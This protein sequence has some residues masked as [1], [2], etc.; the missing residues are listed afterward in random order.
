M[1]NQVRVILTRWH[2]TTN[3]KFSIEALYREQIDQHHPITKNLILSLREFSGLHATV[4]Y[5][6]DDSRNKEFE[7]SLYIASIPLP[8]L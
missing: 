7:K 8:R 5:Y 4:W 2:Y 6:R 3:P 1:D